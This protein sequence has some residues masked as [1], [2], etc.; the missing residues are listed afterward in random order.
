MPL[1]SKPH[2]KFHRTNKPETGNILPCGLDFTQSVTTEPLQYHS[3]DG[4]EVFEN[5]KYFL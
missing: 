2:I 3:T 1:R 5:L 4:Y